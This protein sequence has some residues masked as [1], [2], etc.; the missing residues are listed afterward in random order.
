MK[1]I[2][3]NKYKCSAKYIVFMPQRLWLLFPFPPLS[4]H[5]FD[6]FCLSCTK[7]VHTYYPTNN[8]HI[9]VKVNMKMVSLFQVAKLQLHLCPYSL[10]FVMCIP[11]SNSPQRMP[12]K[13]FPFAGIFDTLYELYVAFYPYKSEHHKTQVSFFFSFLSQSESQPEYSTFTSR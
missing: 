6:I 5:N 4:H 3:R 8:Q 7:N 2:E 10:I 1:V 11:S 9:K 13:C 12:I